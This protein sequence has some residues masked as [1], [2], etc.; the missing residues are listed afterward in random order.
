MAVLVTPLPMVIVGA[1]LIPSEKVAVKV[2]VVVDPKRL[3]ASVSDKV[4]VGAI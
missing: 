3:S 4:T 1:V 2:R